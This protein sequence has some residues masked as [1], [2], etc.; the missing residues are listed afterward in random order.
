[1]NEGEVM[2]PKETLV[3]PTHYQLTISFKS[4]QKEQY[5]KLFDWLFEV[6]TMEF[7]WET[8]MPDK[9]TIIELTVVSCWA[10]N[11]EYIAKLLPDYG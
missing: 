6:E 9:Y 8:K 7:Y 5:K 2:K 3:L 1:M 10:D 4:Q 11:L